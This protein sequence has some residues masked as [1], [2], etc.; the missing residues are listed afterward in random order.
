MLLLIDRIIN[1]LIRVYRKKIFLLKIKSK[2]NTVNVLGKVYVNAT[3][4][5]IGKNVTIYPNVYFWGDGLIEIGDNVDLGIGTIIFAK[6]QVIIG[7]NTAIAAQCYII[8]SNH[9]VKK[10]VLINKQ[11]LHVDSEGIIIGNDVWIAA[12]C[13]IV[14]GAKIS[15]GAVIGALSIVNSEIEKNSIA[16]GIPAKVKKYRE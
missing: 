11:P 2:E 10:D 8:D 6:Q 14:K 3:N 12:G 16:V 5:K 7:N 13:K 1:K 15:D 9:G 4:I